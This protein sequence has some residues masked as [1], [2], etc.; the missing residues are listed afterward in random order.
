MS[1][2]LAI[3]NGLVLTLDGKM[4]RNEVTT[5]SVTEGQSLTSSLSIVQCSLLS[6]SIIF[7]VINENQ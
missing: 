2:L 3:G 4:S 6:I 7:S 5:I 1:I